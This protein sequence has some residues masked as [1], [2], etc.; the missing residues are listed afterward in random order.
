MTGAWSLGFP[1]PAVGLRS[2][3][4]TATAVHRAATGAVARARSIRGLLV[5]HEDLVN[6]PNWLVLQLRVEGQDAIR[7]GAD[8]EPGPLVEQ[9]LNASGYR[10]AARPGPAPHLRRVNMRVGSAGYRACG[11]GG[12]S[13]DIFE[14]AAIGPKSG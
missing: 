13:P 3:R 2:S 11:C 9:A 8:R 12:S 14:V 10:R 5:L 6:L 1:S 4:S 7:L